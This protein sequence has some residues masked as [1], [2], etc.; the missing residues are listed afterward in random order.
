MARIGI[1]LLATLILAAGNS[2]AGEESARPEVRRFGDWLAVC[3]NLN[4]CSAFG[5]SVRDQWGW[6]KVESDAGPGASPRIFVSSDTHMR[7]DDGAFD[8]TIVSAGPPRLHVR[9]DD[10]TVSSNRL[11]DVEGGPAEVYRIEA[12]DV[13]TTLRALVSA[14]RLGLSGD[15]PEVALSLIG[16]GEALGW[17]DDRQGRIGA[18]NALIRTGDR[19]ASTVPNGYPAPPAPT[20]APSLAVESHEVQRPPQVLARHPDMAACLG[21]PDAPLRQGASVGLTRL[22]GDR[23]IWNAPCSLAPSTFYRHRFFLTGRDATDPRLLSFDT[24]HGPTTDPENVEFDPEAGLLFAT[25]EGEPGSCGLTSLWTWTGEA[26]VLTRERLAMSA[27]WNVPE[28]FWPASWR[29]R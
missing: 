17:I 20:A 6:I 11:E 13:P 9:I 5:P 14:K 12:D 16:L 28:A 24:V 25:S 2:H 7:S 26:F 8:Q 4:D 10:L 18:T 15:G 23:E 21:D 22:S 27:C 1:S 19:P 3:D 29:T